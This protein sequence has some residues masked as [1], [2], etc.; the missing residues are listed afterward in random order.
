MKVMTWEKG[1]TSRNDEK[2][3]YLSQL[4]FGPTFLFEDISVIGTE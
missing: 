3:M 2:Y 4:Q 1:F